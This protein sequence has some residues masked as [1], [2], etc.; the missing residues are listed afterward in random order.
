MGA[1]RYL[2]KKLRLIAVGRKK[3]APRWADLRKFNKRA[4]TRRIRVARIKN[5]R[6]GRLK[7]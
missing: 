7:R 1:V 3:A 4:R 6:R 2:P 5:W